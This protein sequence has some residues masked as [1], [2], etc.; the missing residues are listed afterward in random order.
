MLEPVKKIY[1]FLSEQGG[2]PED[3]S[4]VLED[5]KLAAD[6]ARLILSRKREKQD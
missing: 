6:I 5:D 3:I 2:S 4:L 1:G